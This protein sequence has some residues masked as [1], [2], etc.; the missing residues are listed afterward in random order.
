MKSKGHQLIPST[1]YLH[2]FCDLNGLYFYIFQ[3]AVAQTTVLSVVQCVFACV[4]L[5]TPDISCA[6]EKVT[7]VE[8]SLHLGLPCP[9]ILWVLC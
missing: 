8:S 6:L 2:T 7:L 4:W 5:V 1:C 9:W 3:G